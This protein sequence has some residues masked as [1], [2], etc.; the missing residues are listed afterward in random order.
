LQAVTAF[1]D[2]PWGDYRSD[3]VSGG[4]GNDFIAGDDP[5][6]A[7]PGGPPFPVGGNDDNCTGGPG[8]DSIGACEVSAP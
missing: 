7:P 2:A 3:A 5:D 8:T 6:S 4:P 1:A